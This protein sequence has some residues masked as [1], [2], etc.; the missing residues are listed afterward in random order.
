MKKIVFLV[1]GLLLLIAVPATVYFVGEQQDIRSRAAPATSLSF[2]P[3]T[4]TKPQDEQF[5]VNVDINTGTNNVT[6]VKVVV[7][8]DSTK[9]EATSITNGAFAPKITAS[10][11]VASGNASI[12][13]AANSTTSPMNGTGTIAIIRFKGKTGTTTPVQLKFDTNTFASGLTESTNVITT[14]GTASVNISGSSASAAATTTIAPTP[15]QTTLLSS[16]LPTDT[17]A[18]TPTQTPEAT[19]SALVTTDG[20]GGSDEV[21]I[22]GSTETTVALLLAGIGCI[23]FSGLLYSKAKQ[24]V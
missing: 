22:T 9:L 14:M 16:V 1:V 15:T 23:V 20:V 6:A 10:G 3:T 7:T 12:T 18:P 24:T 5:T 4:V 19:D 13:V 17:I 8:F 21:P 11:I 2:N